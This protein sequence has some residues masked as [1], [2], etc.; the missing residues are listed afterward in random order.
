MEVK[1]GKERE[2]EIGLYISCMTF[3]SIYVFVIFVVIR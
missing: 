2:R 3:D 1:S